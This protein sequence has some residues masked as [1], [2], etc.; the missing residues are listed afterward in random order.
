MT[1]LLNEIQS[2]DWQPKLGEIGSVVEGMDD[3]N[4]CI[5]IILTTRKG[6]DP[7]RPEFGADLWQYIDYPVNQAIPNIIREAMDAIHMWE[8]RVDINSIKP[9]V[10]GAHVTLAIEW[11]IKDTSLS[12]NVEVYL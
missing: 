1:T 7:H 12:G 10:D 2:V 6:S 4:Q 11:I 5:R 3:I 9:T 8:P